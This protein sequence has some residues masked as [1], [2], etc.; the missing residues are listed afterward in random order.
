MIVP[1]MNGW[2][3]QTY[4]NVPALAKVALPVAPASMAPVSNPPD[5]VAVCFWLSL[6]VHVTVP[7]T[8]TCVSAGPNLNCLMSTVA[9]LAS[10]PVPAAAV[11][12]VPEAAV[13]AVPE[14]AVVAVPEAAVVGVAVGADATVVT[15]AVLDDDL[16]ELLHDTPSVVNTPKARNVV[17][18]G[19]RVIER[20][21]ALFERRMRKLRNS[22]RGSR[23]AYRSPVDIDIDT[24][25]TVTD[26][27]PAHDTMTANGVFELDDGRWVAASAERVEQILADPEAL[28][29]FDTGDSGAAVQSRMA[30]FTDGALHEQRRA[31]AVERLGR[32][33][34]AELHTRALALTRS[35]LA[36]HG[37]VDLMTT[38]ARFV[39]VAVL[40]SALAD[41]AGAVTGSAHASVLRL[42]QAIAPERG[43]LR[44]DADPPARRIAELIDPSAPF[45]DATVNIVALLFQTID[46][47]AGL[48]G[49]SVVTATRL[50]A[51]TFDDHACSRFVAEV[52][53][54]DPAVHFTTRTAAAEIVLA[55]H[56]IP[57]GATIVVDLA[58]AGRDRSR[59]DRPAEFRPSR[60][61]PS[62]AFGDGRHRCPGRDHA[63]GLASGVF[64]GVLR[65]GGRL[66]TVNVTYE[67]RFNLRIPVHLSWTL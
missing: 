11:V 25:T 18:A 34:P 9:A 41:P 24:L 56:R 14:A 40:S 32:L 5:E 53:R 6:F 57:R 7:P 31:V 33:D 66:T 61:G 10:A 45:D 20:P 3:E 55:G 43:R 27:Y 63:L 64:Q 46:A 48:I 49:N 54:F 13:V 65:S 47:T 21:S 4:A 44:G 50:G 36:R 26:P 22:F 35:V 59:F 52:S 23:R 15:A 51:P 58:A 12:A 8:A 62:F 2:N 30:R 37:T 38:L 60:D 42:A 1:F 39:P 29:G 17:R 19:R 67:R 28:I 16:L